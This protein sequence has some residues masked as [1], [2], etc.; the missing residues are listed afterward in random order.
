LKIKGS[1]LIKTQG[2]GQIIKKE[3]ESE[4]FDSHGGEVGRDLET[5]LTK[6]AT[7]LKQYKDQKCLCEGLLAGVVSLKWLGMV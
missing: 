4:L 5:D 6:M 1:L 7:S 2:K 3:N